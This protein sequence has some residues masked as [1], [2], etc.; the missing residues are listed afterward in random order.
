MEALLPPE[1]LQGDITLIPKSGDQEWIENKRPITL[2]NVV[3]KIFAK[4][5]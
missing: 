3:Y 1:I 4:L 2:L 5:C